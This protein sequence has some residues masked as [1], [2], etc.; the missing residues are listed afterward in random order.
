[1]EVLRKRNAVT[2]IYFPM[3]KA[4][5]QD[6]ATASDWT[7][8]AGDCKYS[9]DGGDFANTTNLPAHEGQGIWSLALAAGE[10]AGKVTAIAIVDSATKAVEDQAI[11]ISTYGDGSAQHPLNLIADHVLRRAVQ[12]AIDSTDGDTK[13]LRSLLGAACKLVNKLAVSGSTLTI[14]EDDDT[15]ALGTQT[16]TTNAAADPITALDTD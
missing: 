7:P 11:L 3:I 10:V 13:G 15:T 6:F 2:A 16:I 12:G 14:Y 8:A 4:G 9:V 5:A 1:M